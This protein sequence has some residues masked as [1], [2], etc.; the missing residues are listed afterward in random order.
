MEEG[1][2]NE[3]MPDVTFEVGG[4]FKIAPNLGKPTKNSV[5]MCTPTSDTKTQHTVS[6]GHVQTRG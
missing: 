2:N 5:T 4:E 1:F 3:G 6:G